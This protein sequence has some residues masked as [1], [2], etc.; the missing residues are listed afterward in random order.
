MKKFFILVLGMIMLMLIPINVKAD[1]EVEIGVDQEESNIEYVEIDQE[2]E[3]FSVGH[4]V[5]LS[6]NPNV[7][8][9]YKLEANK[10]VRLKFIYSSTSRVKVGI[11]N[12]SRNKVALKEIKSNDI[13]KIKVPK[14]DTYSIYIQ[15][16][17]GKKITVS[18][19]IIIL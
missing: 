6:I 3:S 8:K 16:N 14:K 11:V 10:Y 12:K 2:M 19:V 13:Q 1:D 18:G 5:S 7:E 17:S 9:S 4:K 15:N